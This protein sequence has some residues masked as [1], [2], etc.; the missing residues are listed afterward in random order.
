[1]SA[2]RPSQGLH[3][4]GKRRDPEPVT[5]KARTRSHLVSVTTP[6]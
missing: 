5:E 6:P 3:L 4:L 1:M 2:L